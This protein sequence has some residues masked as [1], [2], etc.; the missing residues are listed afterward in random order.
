MDLNEFQ[1]QALQEERETIY[2]SQMGLDPQDLCHWDHEAATLLG[3][4]INKIRAYLRKGLIKRGEEGT[5][6][7]L[8]LDGHNKTER[9]MLKIGDSWTCNCQHF[10]MTTTACSHLLA[11]FLYFS[12]LREA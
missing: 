10:N 11:L 8:A 4:R 1:R 5:W 7:A 6:L 2:A 12:Q 3:S 9:V